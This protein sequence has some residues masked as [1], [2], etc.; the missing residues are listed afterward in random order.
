V[1]VVIDGPL[2][3]ADALW[4]CGCLRAAL[5]RSGAETVVCDVTRL[6]E[7]DL[8]AVDVLAR[9]RL[10]ARRSGRW[11]RLDNPSP[12]LRD[13]LALVGLDEVLRPGGSSGVE[14]GRQ[15]EQREQPGGVE[16]RVQPDDPAG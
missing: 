12:R 4:F 9:F 11:L 15:P 7:P 16:E 1:T 2:R 13:L 14:A 5:E 10:T 6:T 8:E 3:D